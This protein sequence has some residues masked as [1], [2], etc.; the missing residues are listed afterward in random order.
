MYQGNNLKLKLF[1][2]NPYGVN[3]YIYIDLKKNAIYIGFVSLYVD[4]LHSN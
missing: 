2:D 3:S 4:G 1:S